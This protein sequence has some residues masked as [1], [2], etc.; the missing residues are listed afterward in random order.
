[1]F[2]GFMKVAIVSFGHA[3]SAISM[4]KSIS[5]YIDLDLYY[6]FSQDRKR[7]NIID[8]TNIEVNNGFQSDDLLSILIQKELLS[9]VNGAFKIKFFIFKSI[10]LRTFINVLLTIKFAKTLRKYDIV[11]INGT[12]GVLP[13]IIIML[14]NRKM[15]FTIHDYYPHSGEGNGSFLSKLVNRKLNSFIIK[16]KHFAVIQNMADFT[17]LISIEKEARNI[18]Y[19]PFGQLEIYKNFQS[20]DLEN[21]KIS[22]DILF[23]GRISKYKGIE[24]LLKAFER[25]QISFP[26]FKLVI[27]G[28]GDL[29]FD[30]D[31]KYYEDN[32]VFLNRFIDNRELVNLIKNTKVVVCPY[33]DATQSGVAMTAFALGRP[34]VAT[35]V[36][37]FS[38]I[39]NDGINGFIVEPRNSNDLYLILKKVFNDYDLLSR[40]TK[41][42]ES[43]NC[44]PDIFQWKNI[45]NKYLQLYNGN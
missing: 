22:S 16:S 39:I 11:H 14:F 8:F 35:N 33:I 4:A 36:G 24:Y 27:A 9:Y 40:M 42:V 43:N 34:V 30:Y 38:E 1:M 15:V 23:F 28:Q 21:I 6:V 32:I 17:H 18:S 29:D 13:W 10:K 45:A 44:L 26:H 3:D 37:G 12:S 5:E 20:N 2:G 19:I 41:E 25:L 7:N 31:F